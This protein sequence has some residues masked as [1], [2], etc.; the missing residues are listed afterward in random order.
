MSVCEKC[1]YNKKQY[2]LLLDE[3]VGWEK[4]IFIKEN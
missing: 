4:C 2:C 1:K 3:T